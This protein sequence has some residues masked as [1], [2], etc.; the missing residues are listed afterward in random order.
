MSKSW[1]Q[2]LA[3]CATVVRYFRSETIKRGDETTHSE[4]AREH[5]RQILATFSS[6]ERDTFAQ[7]NRGRRRNSQP[8][9]GTIA[10]RTT[11]PGD[12]TRRDDANR[13]V[14]TLL[15]RARPFW[16]EGRALP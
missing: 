15:D 7:E 11:R 14:R 5:S 8:P 4:S 2:A 13:S 12:R 1:R 6:I 10:A 3:T 16:I 9:F